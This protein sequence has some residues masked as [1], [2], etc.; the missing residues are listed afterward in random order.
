MVECV[1]EH[2]ESLLETTYYTYD[3]TSHAIRLDLEVI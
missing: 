2:W 3:T 1:E